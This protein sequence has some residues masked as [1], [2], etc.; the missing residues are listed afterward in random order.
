MNFQATAAGKKGI[1][2]FDVSFSDATGH[3]DLWNGEKCAYNDYFD[4]ASKV[5][6]W[7]CN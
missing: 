1:I 7:I 4:R 3:A 2:V 6:L 5:Y